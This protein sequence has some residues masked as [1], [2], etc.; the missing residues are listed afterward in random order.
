M[1]MGMLKKT[2]MKTC[3][4]A[5]PLLCLQFPAIAADRYI[6]DPEHTSTIFEYDHLGLSLQRARFDGSRGSIT[7]D[8]QGK[9]GTIEIDIDAA[10]INTGNERF[11]NI[12]R[13]ADFFDTEQ[14]PKIIFRS[15]RLYF[16][17]ERLVKAEGDLTIKGVTRP[18]TLEITQFNCRFMLIY[19][20]RACG[21]NGIARIR[22]SEFNLD[23]Y[24]PFVSDAVSL[25]I[26]VEAIKEY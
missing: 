7:L 5:L 19:G 22:R 10:S 8:Q 1:E 25:Y 15:T 13:S 24:A 17:G 20:K 6:V 26:S 2:I 14:H 4:P 23:R 3:W 12:L 16:D 18:T 9:T 21:A 11:N